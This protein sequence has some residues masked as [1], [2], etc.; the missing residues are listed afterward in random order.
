MN[1]DDFKK[2]KLEM[3]SRIRDDVTKRIDA[4]REVTGYSPRSI[5]ISLFLIHAISPDKK[6]YRVDTV[7]ADVEI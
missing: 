2:H 7:S 6:L 5:D 3:E 1:I 4:F